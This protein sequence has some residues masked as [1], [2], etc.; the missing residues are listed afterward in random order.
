MKRKKAKLASERKQRMRKQQRRIKNRLRL[1][2]WT[3]QERPMFGAESVRYDVAERTQALSCGGIGLM[4]MVAVRTGLR[5]EIDRG[6]HLLKRHLPYHESDHVLNIAY[7]LLAGGTALDD[8][9]ERRND[10][11]YLN[12]LGAQRI[13]DPT[14][15]GDFCRRFEAGDVEL[16]M[17]IINETRLGVWARQPEEF[18]EEG[19][20]DVDGTIL[21]TTGECK[22]GMDVSYKGIWGYHPLL[23]S[24]ANTREPL[25]LVN[26][27][28][29][30]PSEEGAAEYLDEAIAVCRRG[31]F[32]SITLRGDTAFSQTKYLD[33][34]DDD[35]VGVLF[36]YQNCPNLVKIATEFDKS[37]WS[38]LERPARYEVQTEERTKPERVKEKIVEDREYRNIRL[39]RESVAEF[40]YRPT[41][42]KKSYR[43]VVIRKDL[44]VIRGQLLLQKDERFFFYIT[45]LR[46]LTAAEIVYKAN[47]RCEQENLI[48]QLKNG[49]R[50]LHA[51]VNNLVSNWAYMVM[52][53]LAW[54]LKAWTALLLPDGGRWQKKH[55]AEKEELLRM[56]FKKFVNQLILIPAQIVR[57]GRRILFRLMAWRRQLS[58]FVRAVEVVERPLR[59]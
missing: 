33:A 57:T 46:D 27:P 51:P 37:A 26:R 58:V 23:V 32:R 47:N 48:D 49:V 56:E 50:A 36:G 19:L 25:F 16:L 44:D 8:I 28:G 31:G 9:E 41:G 24:L 17:G 35:N 20:I 6:L 14:T 21:S 53:S 29:N 10:E 13:P 38:P 1:R 2:E 45:N 43:M 22:D 30:R 7:N 39:V 55:R 40:E 42:C 34:W 5:D 59:C 11:T 3:D 54:T 15:A 4:H 52:A 12:A 18:F